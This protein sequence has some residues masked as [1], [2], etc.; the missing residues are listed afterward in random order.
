MREVDS[1]QI[2]LSNEKTDSVKVQLLLSLSDRYIDINPDSAI[3]F[4]DRVLSAR[5]TDPL[6]AF[7]AR[8]LMHKGSATGRMGN[9]EGAMAFFRQALVV[10]KDPVGPKGLRGLVLRQIG[11]SHYHMAK[12][13]SA[14]ANYQSALDVFKSMKDTL[15]MAGITNNIGNV[16]YF[17]DKK[18]ALVHYNEAL[19]FYEKLGDTE[20]LAK[21]YGNVGLIY[22]HLNDTLKAAEY[23]QKS[24]D[25]YLKTTNRHGIATSHTNLA[26]AL[27]NIGRFAE[28]RAHIGEALAIRESINDR[29]GMAVSTFILG[30]VQ[31]KERKFADALANF[32]K[33]KDLT[34]TQKLRNYEVE[35]KEYAARCLMALGRFAEADHLF[36]SMA[37]ERDSIYSVELKDKV[38]EMD[39]RYRT[40]EKDAEILKLNSEA[41]IADLKL[42]KREIFLAAATLLAFLLSILM[43]MAYI[44]YRN[45][46]RSNVLLEARNA[47]ISRQQIEITDSIRYAK[48]LQQAVLA[49]E[50]TL[51]RI[52][53]DPLLIYQPKDIVSG[54]FYWADEVE[55]RVYFAVVD[56]TGHGVPGAFVSMVG[57]NALNRVVRDLRLTQPAEILDRLSQIVTETLNR[58]EGL[59][60]KDGM[61]VAL[62][63]YDPSTMI[64]EYAGAYSPML[65]V[66]NGEQMLFKANRQPV[67]MT[68]VRTPF[69]NHRIM[70]Q[71][72]DRIFLYSDGLA[73]Q[74]GGPDGKKLGSRAFRQWLVQSANLPMR[75]QVEHV[76]ALLNTWKGTFDQTDDITL[77][78]ICI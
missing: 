3:L 57:H 61:D 12:Y 46:Q 68:D 14:L 49:S 59:T 75:Q 39:A 65:L 78:G 42:R 54:D 7:H 45:K 60:V 30:T 15:R 16:Y 19:R 23:A 50:G 69:T 13:D 28:A 63:S 29:K 20:G 44:A 48:N 2:R 25:Y 58:E 5:Y 41:E 55:G 36:T 67:G 38:A 76:T 10:L 64:L 53:P 17:I 66:R 74:F 6:G 73:D 72:N 51:R 56:C 27:V 37:E 35:C 26:S 9:D 33:A 52:L 47:E 71:H 43:F 18:Q 11:N 70:L 24:L 8:A 40:L 31:Y 77:L 4:A 21:Q 1:L 32:N 22:G 34:H 62:C